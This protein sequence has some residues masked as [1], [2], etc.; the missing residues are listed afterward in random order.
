MKGYIMYTHHP[1]KEIFEEEIKKCSMCDNS[2]YTVTSKLCPF[3]NGSSEAHDGSTCNLCHGGEVDVYDYCEC[4]IGV[5]H[6]VTDHYNLEKE[7]SDYC[8][9]VNDS[10]DSHEHKSF[11]ISS[12]ECFHEYVLE[13]GNRN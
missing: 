8:E 7:W 4:T 2:G 13:F 9:F 1:V 3:C 5:E 6:E 10:E 12:Q 11:M